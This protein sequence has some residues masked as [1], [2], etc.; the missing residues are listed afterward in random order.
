M[1]HLQCLPCFS[2]DA[3]CLPSA[4]LSPWQCLDMPLHAYPS[5]NLFDAGFPHA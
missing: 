3:G 5:K 1:L 4:S 2:L